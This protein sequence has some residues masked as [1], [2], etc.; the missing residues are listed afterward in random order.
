MFNEKQSSIKQTKL[1][2]ENILRGR[3]NYDKLG[4]LRTKPGRIDADPTLSMSCSDK[5]L[6]WTYL[7]LEGSL[8]MHFLEKP[9]Y[10]SSITVEDMYDSESLHR[11]LITRAD[12]VKEL[13]LPFIR[14]KPNIWQSS[15]NLFQYTKKHVEAEY[16]RKQEMAQVDDPSSNNK[17]KKKKIKAD[18]KAIYWEKTMKQPEIIING[19]KQGASP[20]NGVYNKKTWSDLCKYKMFELFY[21]TYQQNHSVSLENSNDDVVIENKEPKPKSYHEFKKESIAY[22]TAKNYLF[23]G[24]QDKP[25]NPSDHNHHEPSQK[26]VLKGWTEKPE[27]FQDFILDSI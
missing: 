20:K 10:L 18:D 19:R 8:L 25:Q 27:G 6:K 17:K 7:G 14:H 11:A 24:C 15:K 21:K 16:K 4:I 23:Y 12:D 9:I 13:P 5:I 22:Q 26:A 1:E 3:L 2:N